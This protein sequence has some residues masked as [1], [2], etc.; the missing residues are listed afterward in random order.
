MVQLKRV[1]HENT[2]LQKRVR[3]G[4]IISYL[5]CRDGSAKSIDNHLGQTSE[6]GDKLGYKVMVRGVVLHTH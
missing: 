4:K 3:K 1:A 2:S 5:G 6:K